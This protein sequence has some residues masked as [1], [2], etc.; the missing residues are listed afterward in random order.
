MALPSALAADMLA[1]C[2]KM[3]AGLS[4]IT[5]YQITPAVLGR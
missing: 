4:L 5:A 2:V 1:S 3:L